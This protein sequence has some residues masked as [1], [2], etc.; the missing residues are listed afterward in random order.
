[1]LGVVSL[2]AGKTLHAMGV[3]VRKLT[4][5]NDS[6]GGDQ[7]DQDIPL[8]RQISVADLKAL[9][10]GEAS[11]ELVDVRTAAEQAIAALEG[12]RLLDQAYHD[13]L[14][15]SDRESSIVFLCHH[16]IRSQQA[17]AYFRQQGFRQVY[18]VQGGIE[19]WSLRIDPTVPRY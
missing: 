15:Q 8:V 2:S 14:L 10:E 1:M 9:V 13:Q 17:A 3:P 19:A 18:N 16:G 7:E 4:P 11:Y 12:F 5:E 6:S